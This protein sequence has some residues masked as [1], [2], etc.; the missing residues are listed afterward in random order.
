MFRQVVDPLPVQKCFWKKNFLRIHEHFCTGQDQVRVSGEHAH[1]IRQLFLH[2]FGQF[3]FPAVFLALQ[4]RLVQIL[5]LIRLVAAQQPA[6]SLDDH[7]RA[8]EG[9]YV[10]RVWPWED[11]WEGNSSVLCA[12]SFVCFV[13]TAR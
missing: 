6:L 2:S 13:P 10:V 9:W 4:I 5:H 8:C 3:V 1:Q 7:V 11:F 12:R